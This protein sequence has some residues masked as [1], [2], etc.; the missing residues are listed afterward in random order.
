MEKSLKKTKEGLV[1]SDKMDKTIV[2]AVERHVIHRLYKKSLTRT[3][4][5]K[6]H[7]AENKCKEGDIVRIMEIRPMSKDKRWVVKEIIGKTKG[8]MKDEDKGRPTHVRVKK[9]EAETEAPS[10]EGEAVVQ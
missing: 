5:F 3:S 1:V 6:V 9:E 4:R 8:K 10:Q 7:D 2:V